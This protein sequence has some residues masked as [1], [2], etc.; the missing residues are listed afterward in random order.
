M[1]PPFLLTEQRAFENQPKG[2]LLHR[3]VMR[4]MPPAGC[5]RPERGQG[6]RGRQRRAAGLPRGRSGLV[7]VDALRDVDEA[8]ILEQGAY[9]HH[10]QLEDVGVPEPGENRQCFLS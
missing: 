3:D 9:F 6:Q 2:C 7:I 1:T 10:Q 5:S 8:I 4:C